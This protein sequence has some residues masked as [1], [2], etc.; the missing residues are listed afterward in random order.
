M[1]VCVFIFVFQEM[2]MI[3]KSNV[4]NDETIDIG[5]DKMLN[6]ISNDGLFQNS[7]SSKEKRQIAQMLQNI[8]EEYV[9]QIDLGKGMGQ[10]DIVIPLSISATNATIT[11]QTAV[12]NDTNQK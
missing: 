6:K 4:K 7:N 8:N 1:F 5:R 11:N 2:T 9:V 3:S 10:G 12:T